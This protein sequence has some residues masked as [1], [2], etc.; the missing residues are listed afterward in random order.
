MGSGLR[1][2]KPYPISEP[3]SVD[4]AIDSAGADALT[5]SALA[6]AMSIGDA[7]FAVSTTESLVV[8]SAL[9]ST[10]SDDHVVFGP[11]LPAYRHSIH[12]II[13]RYMATLCATIWSTPN[14]M[15]FSSLRTIVISYDV[16]CQW[17]KNLERRMI[18]WPEEFKLKDVQKICVIPK[19]HLP[20][21][22]PACHGKYSLNFIFGMGRTDGEGI[23]RGWSESNRCATSTRNMKPGACHDRLD[24]GWGDHN[25]KKRIGLG[26]FTSF[27]PFDRY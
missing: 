15:S 12:I 27:L 19:A 21:H 10:S 25:H 8:Q 6:R 14:N 16:I 7:S 3:P 11:H 20:A 24:H 2:L 18:T 23:E 26:L 17:I 4:A 13:R 1:P 9:P 5:S 22:K